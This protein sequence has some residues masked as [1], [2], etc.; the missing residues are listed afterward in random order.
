MKR[1][2]VF[3]LVGSALALALSFASAREDA[4]R[5]FSLEQPP[6]DFG[7]F[8]PADKPLAALLALLYHNCHTPGAP[9][10]HQGY[11]DLIPQIMAERDHGPDSRAGK[12]ERHLKAHFC[13]SNATLKVEQ[14]HC[15]NSGCLI[16]LTQGKADRTY[17]QGSAL[18]EE[19]REA[20]IAE[21]WFKEE[22]FATYGESPST[23]FSQFW[24]D[25]SVD[26]FEELWVFARKIP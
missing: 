22:Y 3:V 25:A 23:G 17:L 14:I 13:A 9:C 2:A 19:A 21:P 11:I 5:P 24:G 10:G 26:R 4:S 16:D 15:G 12:M 20:L 8:V 1:T 7:G 6:P 18:Y